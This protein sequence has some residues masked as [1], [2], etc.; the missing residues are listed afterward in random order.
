MP[1]STVKY[2]VPG[3]LEIEYIALDEKM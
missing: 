2:R 3:D 1:T